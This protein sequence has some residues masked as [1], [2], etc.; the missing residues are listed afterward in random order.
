QVREAAIGH[1]GHGGRIPLKGRKE[2]HRVGGQVERPVPHEFIRP[3]DGRFDLGLA[4]GRQIACLDEAIEVA[5]RG[6]G[7]LRFRLVTLNRY[8]GYSSSSIHYFLLNPLSIL[9]CMK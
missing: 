7:S 4:S 5:E 1:S 2:L 9:P 3:F 6:N 8:H